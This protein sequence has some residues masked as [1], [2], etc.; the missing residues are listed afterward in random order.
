MATTTNTN[1]APAINTDRLAFVPLT[2]DTDSTLTYGEVTELA[3]SMVSVQRT[4]TQN[5]AKMFA[6][7]Q[8]VASY[9]AKSGGQLQITL[10]SLSSEDEVLLFGKKLDADT[11]ALSNNKDDIVPALMAIYSTVRSDGTRNLYK[12]MKIK[13]QEG[14]ETVETSDDSGVKFQSLQISGSYEQ[15]IKTG[16]DV[17]VVK[18]VNPETE[19]GKAKIE[20]WFGSA[21]GGLP[22]GK[23]PIEGEGE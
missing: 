22:A 21:L 1:R 12:V 23:Y 20:A 19:E 4:P 10:P 8:A 13:F 3:K 6:S 9:V 14:A 16:D 11:S 15:L 2:L 17:I 7:G 5:S 18:G